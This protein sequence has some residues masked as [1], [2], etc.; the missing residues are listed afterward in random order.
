MLNRTKRRSIA[1]AAMAAGVTSMIAVAAPAGAGDAASVDTTRIAGGDRYATALAIAAEV[2]DSPDT[3]VLVNG[4][5]FPDGLA[6]A[7]FDVPIILTPSDTLP[8][9]VLAYLST[10]N[11]DDLD[12]VIILG[13]E[14]AVSAEIELTVDALDL[15][16]ER[17]AGAD[18]YETAADAA[19]EVDAADFPGTSLATAIVATGE[20]FADALAAGPLA[21]NGHPIV[22]TRADSLPEATATALTDGEIERVVLMGGTAAASDVVAQAIT[23]LGIGVVRVAGS[24]RYET[25]A[26]LAATLQLVAPTVYDGSDYGLATGENFADALTSAPFLYGEGAPLLLTRIDSLPSGTVTFL[27]SDEFLDATQVDLFVFGGEAAVSAAAVDTAVAVSTAAPVTAS[28][29]GLVEGTNVFTVTFSEPV[30]LSD[31]PIPATFRLNNGAFAAGG[32]IDVDTDGAATTVTVTTSG[33]PFAPG[34]VVRITGVS[35]AANPANASR[36][37]AT[38]VEADITAPT[39]QILA[40][41]NNTEF[42][43]AFDEAIVSDSVTVSVNGTDVTGTVTFD[44][45]LATFDAANAPTNNVTA[46]QVSGLATPLEAG[47]EVTVSGF[48]DLAGNAVAEATTTVEADDTAPTPQAATV[49]GATG[50]AEA[51]A[52][53]TAGAAFTVTATADGDL[54][55]AVANGYSVQVVDAGDGVSAAV[56]VNTSLR[57]ITIAVDAGTTTAADVAAVIN[58]SDTLSDLITA[59]VD[60]AGV[61]TGPTSAILAGGT[62]TATVTFQWSE[63]IANAM[64]SLHGIDVDADGFDDYT[65]AN[66]TRVDLEDSLEGIL[67]ATFTTDDTTVIEL[68]EAGTSTTRL[69][70]G[71]VTDLA[72]NPSAAVVTTLTVSVDAGDNGDD[73][74]G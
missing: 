46:V 32:T 2:D 20:N 67:R 35:S 12:D 48:T 28:I 4:T 55:G 41:P 9:S 27:D 19:D 18:R 61:I 21:S 52:T 30:D 31:G 26:L 49:S 45:A 43:V 6:A 71:A 42:A 11:G 70:P 56:S 60:T 5:N 47:D 51:T 59:S 74:S 16:V 53:V 65:V 24:D 64:A 50:E 62:D 57:R 13:G 39:A 29:S 10:E 34:D 14:A 54:D 69:G 22:L 58:G 38:T 68:P 23:D 44:P 73:D 15:D 17:I 66:A 33:S 1:T 3:V 7:G 36:S 25:A 37:V 63:P 72:N 40:Y 8:T